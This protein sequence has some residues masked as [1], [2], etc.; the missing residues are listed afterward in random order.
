V[1]PDTPPS[2]PAAN[3]PP[4]DRL[5]GGDDAARTVCDICG[6]TELEEIRCKIICRNCHTILS[7]CSDL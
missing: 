5:P 1:T 7:T 4:G 6:S 3:I 2:P